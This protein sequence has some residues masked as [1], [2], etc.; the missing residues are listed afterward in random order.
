MVNMP[1]IGEEYHAT[2]RTKSLVEQHQAWRSDLPL[3]VNGMRAGHIKLVG[4]ADDK[5]I[6]DWM[7][8][9]MA[10][11]QP[12]EEQFRDIVSALRAERGQPPVVLFQEQ[13]KSSFA[14]EISES[15][16]APVLAERMIV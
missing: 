15:Q 4:A 6:S 14:P 12:F 11:L 13:Q 9:L 10:G 1:S 3:I 16:R 7:T 2:W 8:E 5:P